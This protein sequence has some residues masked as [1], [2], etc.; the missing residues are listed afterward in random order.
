MEWLPYPF[1]QIRLDPEGFLWIFVMGWLIATSCGWVGTFLILR[2]SALIGDAISHS[3]LP[4]IVL[5]FLLTGTRS[6]TAM[7][8]G[9]LVAGLL[10]TVAI[11]WVYRKTRL[12]EDAA[13]GIVFSFFFAVGVILM[14]VFASGVDLDLDCVLYGEIA[15]V[16]LEPYWE[17]GG[18]PV[19]PQPVIMAGLT[20][21]LVLGLILLLFK[22]LQVSS[23]DPTFS[24]TVGINSQAIHYVL[25]VVLSLTIVSAFESVGAVLVIAMLI[26]P[27]STGYLFSDR[28]PRLLAWIPIFAMGIS[29]GGIY[30]S[31]LLDC[32]TAG[33]M[34]MAAFAQFLAVWVL[35]PGR[36]LLARF[37]RSLSKQ[38]P[39]AEEALT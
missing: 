9:A 27:G 18:T 6:S 28:L 15:F 4:G 36:G 31:V 5:A 11:D 22:E 32:S 26:I 39:T 3:I 13:I 12:K 19:A 14:S 35:A 17:M 23:F 30:L 20:L 34:V 38:M 16:S 21:L 7:M 10:T 25:V 8:A 33:A 24:R 1:E 2:K 37:R 29:A